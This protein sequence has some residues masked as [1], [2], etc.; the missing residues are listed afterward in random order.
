MKADHNIDYRS[1]DAYNSKELVNL[2]G[3]KLHMDMINFM[4]ICVQ[5]MKAKLKSENNFKTIQTFKDYDGDDEESE[6]DEERE[7]DEVSETD[8]GTE[9]EDIYNELFSSY[10]ANRPYNSKLPGPVGGQWA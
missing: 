10:Q 6:T 5:N 1:S 4:S 9:N 7:T 2:E 8:E 3:R